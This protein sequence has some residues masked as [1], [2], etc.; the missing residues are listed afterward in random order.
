[1]ETWLKL[2][3]TCEVKICIADADKAKPQT[4]L[5]IDLAE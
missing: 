1:M 2:Y 5:K 4:F 3:F